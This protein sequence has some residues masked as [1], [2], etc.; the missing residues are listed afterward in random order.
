LR[1]A[2]CLDAFSGYPFRT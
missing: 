2:S 1:E